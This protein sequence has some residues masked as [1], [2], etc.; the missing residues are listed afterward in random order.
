MGIYSKVSMVRLTSCC[1]ELQETFLEVVKIMDNSIICGERGEKAQNDAVKIGASNTPFPQSKHNSHPSLAVDAEPYPIIRGAYY[2]M[3]LSFFAGVVLT[4]GLKL[5]YKI[6]W[7]GDWDS[8]KDLSDNNLN[9]LYHFE[10][11]GSI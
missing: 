1:P 6:R 3:R 4:T 5:G 2:K 11:A 9:D 7:G 10:Y 8:D